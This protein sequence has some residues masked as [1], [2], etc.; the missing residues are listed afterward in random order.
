VSSKKFF[1]VNVYKGYGKMHKQRKRKLIG[2]ASG[3]IGPSSL[4][5]LHIGIPAVI[6]HMLAIAIVMQRMLGIDPQYVR[7]ICAPY[8]EY[9]AMSLVLVL[10]G[11]LLYEMLE[12]YYK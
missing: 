8:L 11:S 6:L 9:S 5:I 3:K 1:E 10:M 2:D 12:R 4:F 7:Y